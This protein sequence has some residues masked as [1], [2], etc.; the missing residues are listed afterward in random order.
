M[1]Y[2]LAPDHPEGGGKA[3]FFIERGYDPA[4]HWIF[5]RDLRRL[6][7]RGTVTETILT[8]YG[9]KFIV[10]GV[11][12]TPDGTCARLRT[13]WIIKPAERQPRFVTAYPR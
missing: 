7:R 8:D 6:A 5:R 4:R 2:L 9:M 13:V 3:R 10:D 11:V 12:D 1:R